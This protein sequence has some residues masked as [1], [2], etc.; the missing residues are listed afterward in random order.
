VDENNRY[1]HHESIYQPLSIITSAKTATSALPNI[2]SELSFAHTNKMKQAQEQSRTL[3]YA[4]NKTRPDY[5][6]LELAF[7]HQGSDHVHLLPEEH[8]PR[9]TGKLLVLKDAVPNKP[10]PRDPRYEV[11]FSIGDQYQTQ[12]FVNTLNQI[13]MQQ[14]GTQLVQDSAQYSTHPNVPQNMPYIPQGQPGTT[15]PVSGGPVK[16]PFMAPGGAV[17]G[18]IKRPDQPVMPGG[19]PKLP[20]QMTVVPPGMAQNP[21]LMQQRRQGIRLF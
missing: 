7:M 11:E 3:K 6:Q 13:E 21:M 20:P 16:L 18:M 5:L 19:M 15:Q 14:A 17:P 1:L 9:W 2:G 8:D 4:I 10:P 12:L